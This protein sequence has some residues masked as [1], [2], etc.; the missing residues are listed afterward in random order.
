[1]GGGLRERASTQDVNE[2]LHSVLR[3]DRTADSG[4]HRD[5]NKCVGS[6][7]PEHVMAKKGKRM[8]RV[9]KPIGC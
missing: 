4:D 9:S 6:P 3:R 8:M 5:H 1:M 7:S 2:D